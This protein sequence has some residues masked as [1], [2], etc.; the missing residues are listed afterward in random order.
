M[1]GFFPASPSLSLPDFEV[2][3]LL[4][5]IKCKWSLFS[6]NP[7]EDSEPSLEEGRG[8]IQKNRLTLMPVWST[9][10]PGAVNRA[11]CPGTAHDVS[12]VRPWDPPSKLRVLVPLSSTS[13]FV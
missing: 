10:C 3:N 8:S 5:K 13:I 2:T 6:L 7:K 9:S 11:C 4:A 12:A 1:V